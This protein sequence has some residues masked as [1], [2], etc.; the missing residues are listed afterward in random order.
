[1]T[2]LT[3]GNP[4]FNFPMINGTPFS[5]FNTNNAA[6]NAVD[7]IFTGDGNQVILDPS[8]I[9]IEARQNGSTQFLIFTQQQINDN[10]LEGANPV[11]N[12][13]FGS[14]YPEYAGLFYMDLEVAGGN[15]YAGGYSNNPGGTISALYLIVPR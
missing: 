7:V 9:F 15:F 14:N 1:M 2:F 12:A 4:N 13:Y 11:E 8:S 3:A 10:A 6:A 5:N